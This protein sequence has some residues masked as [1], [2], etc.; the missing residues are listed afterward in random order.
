MIAE[1]EAK[2]KK[3]VSNPMSALGDDSD[4]DADD[5]RHPLSESDKRTAR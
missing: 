5:V 4:D 2:Q 1:E 3:T